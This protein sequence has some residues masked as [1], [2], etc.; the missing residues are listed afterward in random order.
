[1]AP[2]RA[3]RRRRGRLLLRGG[4]RALA[5]PPPD[6]A[7]ALAGGRGVAGDRRGTAAARRGR[8]RLG[9]RSTGTPRAR[10][11]SGFWAGCARA[12]VTSTLRVGV[13]GLGVT[14][15]VPIL[16]STFHG[17]PSLIQSGRCSPTLAVWPC[18]RVCSA[19]TV[20]PLDCT[21][22]RNQHRPRT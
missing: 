15:R 20:P 4:R 3:S 11:V 13:G 16:A 7:R 1:G 14:V 12:G 2:Q 8:V 19:I 21:R 10:V 22:A 5:R 18:S 9:G 6:R 17:A